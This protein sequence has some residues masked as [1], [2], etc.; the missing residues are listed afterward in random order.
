MRMRI[1]GVVGQLS[2]GDSHEKLAVGVVFEVLAL[3]CD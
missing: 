3:V 1:K 2:V